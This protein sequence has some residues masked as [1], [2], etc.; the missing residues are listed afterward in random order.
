VRLARAARALLL[1]TGA[2]AFSAAIGADQP[3]SSRTVMA[4]AAQAQAPS[5]AGS[6]DPSKDAA[7]RG[8]TLYTANCVLCHGEGGRGDGRAAKLYNPRPADLTAST[9]SDTYKATIIRKGGAFVGRSMVMPA[10]GTELSDAQIQDLVAYLRV[11]ARP[12]GIPA[13]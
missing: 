11:I 8:R 5:A 7:E 2:A 10:W 4:A 6:A 1:L 3:T 9:R 12:A 13:D